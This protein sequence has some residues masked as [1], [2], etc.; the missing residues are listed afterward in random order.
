MRVENS[1]QVGIGATAKKIG[2]TLEKTNKSLSSIM[3]KLATG[4]RINRAKDDAAG[5]A[6]S[7]GLITQTRGFKMAFRNTDDGVSAL[8]IAEGAANETTAILQ[9]QR[10]LA[11]AARNATLTDTE[12]GYLNREFQQLTQEIDRISQATTFNKQDLTNGQGLGAGDAQ[13]QVGPNAGEMIAT[14]KINYSAAALGVSSMDI[15][16]VDGANA[17]LL[18]I[19]NALNNINEQRSNV[20]A[21][22]NRLE[23]T[24]KNLM[25]A[26]INTTAAQSVIRDQD[27]ALGVAEMVRNQVLT[28]SGINAFSVFNRISADHILGLIK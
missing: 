26:D 23:S 15:G 20:G 27:M 21:L 19:D 4:Q 11:G 25:T 12:R 5:L 28:K 8:N 22:T 7:E 10:E 13:L 24:M 3:E 18:T 14:D 6:I 16:S 2:G 9:R 1:G 17:A